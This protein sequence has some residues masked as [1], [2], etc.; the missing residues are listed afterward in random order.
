M[1]VIAR[2]RGQSILIGQDIE[3]CVLRI[4]GNKVRLGIR[5][6]RDEQVLRSELAQ[7]S[8]R[9]AEAACHVA[10]DNDGGAS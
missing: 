7:Q 10:V 1:L 8:P 2:K 4:S 3:V 5:A 6:P 9:P